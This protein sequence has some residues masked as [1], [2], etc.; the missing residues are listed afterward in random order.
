MPPNIA[1]FLFSWHFYF[2]SRFWHFIKKRCQRD[3]SFW[4]NFTNIVS[5]TPQMHVDLRNRGTSE[6][7][8]LLNYEMLA[9]HQ[10]HLLVFISRK[11]FKN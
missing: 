9:L 6:A 7:N 3:L 1:K 11:F 5:V 4:G 8:P 10:T 2:I